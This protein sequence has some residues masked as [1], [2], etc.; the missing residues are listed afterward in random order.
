LS[1]VEALA[2]VALWFAVASLGMVRHVVLLRRYRAMTAA[3]SPALKRA[4][5]RELLDTPQ[6]DP[7]LE[8]ARRKCRR[9]LF[10]GLAVY[11]LCIPLL[12]M[13]LNA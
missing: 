1:T 8:N 11:F 9:W 6:P 5:D 12:P 2:R 4:S 3:A 10:A 13:I 7:V